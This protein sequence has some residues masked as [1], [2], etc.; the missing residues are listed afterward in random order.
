[1]RSADLS[2]QVAAVLA[3]M[4][5]APNEVDTHYTW[6]IK[7]LVSRLDPE[8]FTTDEKKAIVALMIP[9]HSRK[10][11]AGGTQ[12]A[13]QIGVLP[14]R[15]LGLVPP[16]GPLSEPAASPAVAE[17]GAEFVDNRVVG[18]SG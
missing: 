18:E 9:V 5:D 12:S 15:R 7:E 17:T 2:Q 16:L 6:M 14:K 1:M 11:A 13:P 4:S 10:L 3:Y 8:D